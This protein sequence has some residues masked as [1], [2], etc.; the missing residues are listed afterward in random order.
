MLSG[1]QDGHGQYNE[2]HGGKVNVKIGVFI[3]PLFG[4]DNEL[5]NQRS[6][7]EVLDSVVQAGVQSI[8]IG[9]SD[10]RTH[11]NNPDRLLG[12]DRESGKLVEMTSLRSLEISA[13]NC[14]GN[15]LHPNEE[16]RER[17][18]ERMNKTI[19]LADK[20]E[21]GRVINFSGCPGSSE[22]SK[23]PNWI[24]Y[25]GS[26]EVLEWQ[27]NKIAIP[28]WRKQERFASQHNV[29]ICLEIHPCNLVYNC[30]SF[31]K[32]RQETGKN[33][34]V[35]LD[36]SHFFWQSID[37]ITVIH[38]LGEAVSHVHAKDTAINKVNI[39]KNGVLDPKPFTQKAHRSWISRTVGYGH[40]LNFWRTFINA[41]RLIGYD[42]VL[43]IEQVDLLFSREEGLRKG[44]RF[45]EQIL[46][47]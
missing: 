41:L 23:Y 14:T 40:S 1:Q 43:S 9:M 34:R 35:N 32:L 16:T 28:F 27:W 42:D 26:E 18:V 5:L 30:E 46:D 10:N 22:N 6:F 4:F 12:D 45:L 24:V 17:D 8:E 21:V 7:E 15:P 20:L 13:L 37:P 33:L 31:L 19:L 47:N 3:Q 29:K 2:E 25:P 44:V 39:S 36:P 11:W 38:E